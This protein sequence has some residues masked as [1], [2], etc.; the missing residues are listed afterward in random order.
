MY[1]IVGRARVRWQHT[2]GSF[3]KSLSS[4]LFPFPLTALLK[5]GLTVG[6]YYLLDEGD[7]MG[8]WTIGT[9]GGSD[10]AQYE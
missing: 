6:H 7:G 10:G 9:H 5:S 4:R 8:H 2:G 1:N 3:V